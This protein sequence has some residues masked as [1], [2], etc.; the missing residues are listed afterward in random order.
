MVEGRLV[1]RQS[2]AR[3]ILVLQLLPAQLFSLSDE[4][5]EKRQKIFAL[6]LCRALVMSFSSLS[7]LP[8]WG[9]YD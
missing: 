8:E 7:P 9:I 6:A 4:K 3:V 2:C 1:T 5:D